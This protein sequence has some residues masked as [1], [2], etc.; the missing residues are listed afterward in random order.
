MCH[1]VG[2]MLRTV[3]GNNMTAEQLYSRLTDKDGELHSK[4]FALMEN[5]RGSREYF[6]KLGMDV[7]W[8]IRHL[9]PPTLF[10]TRS[11][12]ERFSEPS[13]AYLRQINSSVP[14]VGSMTP[15]EVCAM[16]PFNVSIHFNKKWEAI[17]K[18]LIQAKEQ[19]IFGEVVEY[20]W[21]VEYQ[22]RGAPHVHCL[23]WVEAAP[24][25][26]KRSPENVKAYL[27]KIVTCSMPDAADHQHCMNS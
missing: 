21:R 13:I 6:S 2:H 12:A 1:S 8:M 7:R 11:A 5:L 27:S 9:E 25:L 26:R 15:A 24:I 3:T 4:M 14:N 16:D 18:H 10:V 22:C 19:P 17:F 23:L 20:F